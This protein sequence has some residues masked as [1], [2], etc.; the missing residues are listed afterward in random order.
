MCSKGL[1]TVIDIFDRASSWRRFLLKTRQLVHRR[2][3]TVLA[4]PSCCEE[5]SDV[6]DLPF[7]DLHDGGITSDGTKYY[8][9][10]TTTR[11]YQRHSN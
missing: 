8:R 7:L 11:E 5:H 10:R 4:S 2:F 9:P 6:E 3:G 1:G